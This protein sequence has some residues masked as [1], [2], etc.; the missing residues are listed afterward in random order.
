MF[1]TR[2]LLMLG[3]MLLGAG[4]DLATKSWIFNRLGMP[5]DSDTQWIISGVFGF[6][7][8]LNAGALFGMGQG[9]AAVFAAL[10]FVAMFGLA[11]W[12]FVEAW[13]SRVL[14]VSFGMI[15]AG[16]IGNLYDRLGLHSLRWTEYYAPSLDLI[17]Q[18]AYAVRD[19]I[20]IMIGPYPWP[21]FNIADPL[22]LF[23]VALIAIHAA[24]NPK[25]T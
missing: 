12:F 8:S 23:G 6:Q 15:L 13:Q 4:V 19:W 1:R 17:G 2:L 18:P 11:F 5:G 10:A 3:I 20:L 9:F 7:T 16:I 21:N 25:S 14:T 24:R 22:L